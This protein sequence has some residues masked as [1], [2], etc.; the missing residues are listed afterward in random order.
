[1]MRGS[2]LPWTD[3]RESCAED[4][5]RTEDAHGA[6]CVIV[7][8]GF[9]EGACERVA[10]GTI[11]SRTIQPEQVKHRGRHGADRPFTH[12]ISNRKSSGLC[13][14][15]VSGDD[16]IASVTEMTPTVE[17]VAYVGELGLDIGPPRWWWRTQRF[18]G[19]HLVRRI[20]APKRNVELDSQLAVG[21]RENETSF[22]E[23][24]TGERRHGATR[25]TTVSA[26]ITVESPLA[27][28]RR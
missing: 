19:K 21:N 16:V 23:A 22:V 17:V 10:L 1:M 24:R 13:R 26:K 12:V 9:I 11:E 8:R 4:G 25:G 28:S 7:E 14:R 2:S 27:R 18:E 15:V 20:G 5:T 6:R 3:G